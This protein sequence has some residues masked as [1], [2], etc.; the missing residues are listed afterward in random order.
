[1]SSVEQYF[2]SMSAASLVSSTVLL[3]L[4]ALLMLHL[5]GGGGVA[6]QPCCESFSQII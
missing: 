4:R 5:V 3:L 2:C 1:M 6:F